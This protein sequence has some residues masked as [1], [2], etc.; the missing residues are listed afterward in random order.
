MHKRTCKYKQSKSNSV[1]RSIDPE[2]QDR[3]SVTTNAD[4]GQADFRWD[5]INVNIFCQGIT[6]AYEE[7]VH[8]KRNN[9]LVPSG[10]VGKSFIRELARLYQSYADNAPLQCIA[11]KACSVMQSLLLQKP[12]AKSK[13]KEHTTHLERRMKLWA[14]GD[15]DGLLHEGKCI[16]KHLKSNASG[17]NV[18]EKIARGFNRL[19]LQGKVRRATRLISSAD[20]RGLLSIDEL[21]PIGVDENGNTTYQTT[22]EIRMQK[23][24][25]GKVPPA[26]LLLEETQNE[27]SYYDPIIFE[28]I[29][30]DTITQ[31]ANRTQG[32]AGPS[33]LDAHAWRRFCFRLK[34]PLLIYAMLWLG[35]H[36]VC[37]HHLFNLKVCPHLLLVA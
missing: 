13:A 6:K 3:Q 10:K 11:L 7:I 14:Q 16:Q 12:H 19:M 23:H 25:E 32:A 15:I 37:V 2:S 34:A 33:G 29:T 30:G 26:E 17:T 9:F 36:A 27:D 28:R 35:W 4:T 5:E 20:N 1:N 22:R 24:P 31:A 8:W 21:V 18:I